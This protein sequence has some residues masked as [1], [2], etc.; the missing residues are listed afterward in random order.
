ML[1]QI[2]FLTLLVDYIQLVANTNPGVFQCI[3][4]LETSNTSP[5]QYLM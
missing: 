2:L 4:N 1:S 5:S 3:A